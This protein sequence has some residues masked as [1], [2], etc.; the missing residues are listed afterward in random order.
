M[1]HNRDIRREKAAG[2]SESVVFR[3]L[4]TLTKE[5]LDAIALQ[6]PRKYRICHILR[7]NTGCI[8]VVSQLGECG[9]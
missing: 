2:T 8:R 3:L 6:A 4:E 5:I 1:R 9:V 7:T